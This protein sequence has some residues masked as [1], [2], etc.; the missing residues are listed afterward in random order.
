[1]SGYFKPFSQTADDIESRMSFQSGMFREQ[2]PDGIH[3][4]KGR[5]RLRESAVEVE[6]GC[7]YDP[8]GVNL[9][10]IGYR[11]SGSVVIGCRPDIRYRFSNFLLIMFIEQGTDQYITI[12]VERNSAENEFILMDFCVGQFGY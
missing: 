5:I 10:N 1:M 9:C 7:L 6:L 8:V 12:H 2:L 3:R 11:G 4:P